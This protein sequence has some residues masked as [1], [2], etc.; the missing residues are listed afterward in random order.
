MLLR[1]GSGGASSLVAVMGS[2]EGRG[3]GSSSRACST[4][5]SA[6]GGLLVGVFGRASVSIVLGFCSGSAI[7]SVSIGVLGR[8]IVASSS[9]DCSLSESEARST[10]GLSLETLTVSIFRGGYTAFILYTLFESLS[11]T[12]YGPSHL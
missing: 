6:A 3:T 5:V 9:S 12:S 10:K 4:S 8:I 2:G 11:I 1:G 7:L